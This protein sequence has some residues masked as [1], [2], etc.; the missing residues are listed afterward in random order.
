MHVA[1]YQEENGDYL[2]IV[3]DRAYRLPGVEEVY[4]GRASAIQGLPSSVQTT[5]IARAFI[6]ESCK[7]VRK[8]DIPQE[9]RDRM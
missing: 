8:A 6:R 3:W 2:M 7:R 1:Y 9:W 5:G 4:E